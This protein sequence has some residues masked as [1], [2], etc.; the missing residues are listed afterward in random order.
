MPTKKWAL[1]SETVILKWLCVQ[2]GKQKKQELSKEARAPL[3]CAPH[4]YEC[5]LR[6]KLA[7]NFPGEPSAFRFLELN[8]EEEWRRN[9]RPA[10]FFQVWTR[11]KPS[12]CHCNTFFSCPAATILSFISPPSF[13]P[14]PPFLFHL[15]SS[16]SSLNP[17]APAFPPALSHL[18]S[19]I[20]SYFTSTALTHFLCSSLCGIYPPK[21]LLFLS[22]C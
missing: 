8:E 22:P 13:L 11:A 9:G 4:V 3:I 7:H 12:F 14:F 10:F 6:K 20:S 17:F 1:V 15:S 18:T 21:S 16:F 19:P 2:I 5:V